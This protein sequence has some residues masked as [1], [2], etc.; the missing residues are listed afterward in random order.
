MFSTSP[1]T[2]PQTSV[3][4]RVSV[5]FPA[6]I[7]VA[8][9]G[10]RIFAKHNSYT[11]ESRCSDGVIG[12]PLGEPFFTKTSI[13]LAAW[14]LSHLKTIISILGCDVPASNVKFLLLSSMPQEPLI[15]HV[16][17]FTD[18]VIP[19]LGFTIK[20]ISGAIELVLVDT[21]PFASKDANVALSCAALLG[22]SYTGVPYSSYVT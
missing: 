14:R 17:L 18:I 1:T 3:S 13:F 7:F 5:I 22:L 6:V 4:S 10:T 2:I 8:L 19:S 20:P 16:P 12:S 21:I 9:A 15:Q 11:D